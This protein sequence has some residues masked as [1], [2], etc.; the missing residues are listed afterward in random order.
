MVFIGVEPFSLIETL[1]GY[2]PKCIE[3]RGIEGGEALPTG[4]KK[5]FLISAKI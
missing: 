4:I 2:T 5:D 1:D 3:T